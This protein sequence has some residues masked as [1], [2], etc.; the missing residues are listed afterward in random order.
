MAA[1]SL[2]NGS[3]PH[4]KNITLSGVGDTMQ[5]I[6]VPGNCRRCEIVFTSAAGKLITDGTDA[7]V[8][9]TEESFPI[10]ADSAFYVDISRASGN[11]SLY[12]ASA[13]PSTV[14]SVIVTDGD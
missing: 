4:V 6:E 2:A 5:E 7:T 12:L 13:T 11:F 3:Y 1:V 9:S 14:V 8:I 10:P